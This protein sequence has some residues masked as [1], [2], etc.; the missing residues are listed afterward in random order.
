M[1]LGLPPYDRVPSN[2][3]GLHTVP[4]V[5]N[6]ASRQSSIFDITNREYA[7][8]INQSQ[9]IIGSRKDTNS[10]MSTAKNQLDFL[11]LSSSSKKVITRSV[12][13]V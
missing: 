8:V 3:N 9:R 10:S 7:M 1:R 11:T 5:Q 4:D 2:H 13:R 6:T 12:S